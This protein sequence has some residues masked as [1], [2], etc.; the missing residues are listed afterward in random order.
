M[1]LISKRDIEKYLD[2]DLFEIFHSYKPQQKDSHYVITA[3]D[4]N[5][6]KNDQPQQNVDETP[7]DV[8]A[9]IAEA[10]NLEN[11]NY[12][13]YE[14]YSGDN[15]LGDAYQQEN[16]AEEHTGAVAEQV[17]P[18]PNPVPAQRAAVQ[19]AAP[20]VPGQQAANTRMAEAETIQQTQSQA[21]SINANNQQR[22][23]IDAVDQPKIPPTRQRRANQQEATTRSKTPSRRAVRAE[24]NF[25]NDATDHKPQNTLLAPHAPISPKSASEQA[26]KATETNTASAPAKTYSFRQ[27][28]PHK[29]KP[30]ANSA[31]NRIK[32]VEPKPK[33]VQNTEQPKPSK[34]QVN[35]QANKVDLPVQ[36]QE[37]VRQEPQMKAEDNKPQEP[38]FD[39]AEIAQS[40]KMSKALMA[41]T[42][43]SILLTANLEKMTLKPLM[44]KYLKTG[45]IMN[46]NFK[47]D[48]VLSSIKTIVIGGDGTISVGF[49]SGDGLSAYPQSRKVP[50]ETLLKEGFEWSYEPYSIKKLV[51]ELTP[52]CADITKINAF[53]FDFAQLTIKRI[54]LKSAE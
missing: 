19:Q 51:K 49:N 29:P 46:L 18:V 48:N 11:T 44:L 39:I 24:N 52:F 30:Q 36:K 23:N 31:A 34:P 38:Q 32:T 16:D 14:D 10:G 47:D 21:Q 1:P 45:K 41:A 17:V 13:E 22:V 20:Q 6:A 40:A 53:G 43:E 50:D 8:A 35:P 15:G 42:K 28:V 5:K 9:A 27:P 4:P 54:I 37:Q 25:A 3:I 12:N 2:S 26:E 33:V 7:E